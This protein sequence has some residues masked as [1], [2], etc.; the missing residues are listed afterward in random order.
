MDFLVPEEASWSQEES[1]LEPRMAPGTVRRERWQL[2][3][4]H[5]NGIV[6]HSYL[7]LVERF[8][9]ARGFDAR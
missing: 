4:D 5:E 6:P 9:I 7:Q 3:S 1:A 2:G 8:R